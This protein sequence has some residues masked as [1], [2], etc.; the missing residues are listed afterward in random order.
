[1]EEKLRKYFLETL[2][3]AEIEE[4]ELRLIS[5]AAFEDEL[6]LAREILME[7]YL[8]EMLSPDEVEKFRTNFLSCEKRVNEVKILAALKIYARRNTS[9]ETAPERSENSSG[10]FFDKLAAFFSVNMRPIAAAAVILISVFIGYI[11]LIPEN[12]ELAELNGRNLQNTE[13]YRNLTNLS[14]ASG[15][16]RSSDQ[17][18]AISA[19]KLTDTVFLRLALTLEGEFFDVNITGNE[20][21]IA[22][23]LRVRAYSNQNGREIRLLL[24]SASLIPGNYKI[25]VFPA[26]ISNTPVTYSFAVR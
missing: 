26:D 12:N 22:S 16:L 18:S 24:P 25:E 11:F 19:D 20:K 2:S 3:P 9:K 10:S 14:L 13:E 17:I 8:D 15:I 6:I 1:M 23:G 4:I 21:K 7:D 5:D